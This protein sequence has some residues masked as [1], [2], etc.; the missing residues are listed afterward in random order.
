M[1]QVENGIKNQGPQCILVSFWG[2]VK[3]NTQYC[4][5]IDNSLK[6]H[7]EIACLVS[8][9]AQFHANQCIWGAQEVDINL[10]S[11][12]Q[13]GLLHLKH[14]V[15]CLGCKKQSANVERE[16]EDNKW[17]KI[18]KHERNMKRKERVGSGKGQEQKINAQR[19]TTEDLRIA[20]I[21]IIIIRLASIWSHKETHINS[22]KQH[23][24]L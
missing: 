11:L 16:M 17:G 15:F 4:P 2:H 24:F 3:K 6:L 14:Q 19:D 8:R 23:H 21:I 13:S 9:L 12:N 1:E 10:T 5:V 18:R 20:E 7:M 22:I